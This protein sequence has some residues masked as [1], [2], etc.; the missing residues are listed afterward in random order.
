VALATSLRRRPGTTGCQAAPASQPFPSRRSSC[1]SAD[2]G[3]S[4]TPSSR[5]PLRCTSSSLSP[6][7]DSCRPAGRR[8]VL[9]CRPS[10]GPP[11]SG[12]AG[13]LP[14]ASTPSCCTHAASP[15]VP[16][17]PG[18]ESRRPT[19]PASPNRAWEGD[20]AAPHA[21]RR[22]QELAPQG[23]C[24]GALTLPAVRGQREGKE[25]VDTCLRAWH[26][27]LLASEAVAADLHGG[28]CARPGTPEPAPNILQ[29]A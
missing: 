21:R 15:D 18:R 20:A 16:E 12:N 28:R 3:A 6:L 9:S 17:L 13:A 14:S 10:A 26:T 27:S 22:I 5:A 23:T 7:A 24:L 19:G 29:T 11:I 8:T 4:S 1:A 2:L 25:E